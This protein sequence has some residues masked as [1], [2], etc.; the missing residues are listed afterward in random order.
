MHKKKSSSTASAVKA[1]LS[2]FATLAAAVPVHAVSLPGNVADHTL[3]G[4]PSMVV[5][6]GSWRETTDVLVR[7]TADGLV[8][9]GLAAKGWNI[10]A[11]DDDWMVRTDC[12]DWDAARTPV[13]NCSG[14]RDANGH[15]IA[16]PSKYPQGIQSTINY[17]H[18]KGLKF[19][20]YTDGGS[21]TCDGGAAMNA[22]SGPTYF[23]SD[24]NYFASMGVD[25]IKSDYCYNINNTSN[26]WPLTTDSDATVAVDAYRQ[27][28]LA[29]DAANA[30]YGTH[31]VL[32]PSPAAYFNWHNDATGTA[33]FQKVVGGLALYAQQWRI[34]G[35]NGGSTWSSML[36]TLDQ[37]VGTA[38]FAR[39]GHFN[40]LDQLA[41]GKG[42]MTTA[43]GQSEFSLWAI[44]AAPLNIKVGVTTGLTAQLVSDAG[45]TDVIAISQ[46]Q[47]GAQGKRIYNDAN[48]SVFTKPLANGD[49]AVLLLNKSTTAQTISTSG[50]AVGTSATQFS[51]TDV[52]SKAV[53][54]STGSISASVPATS[55]ILYRLHPTSNAFSAW[56]QARNASSISDDDASTAGCFDSACRSFSSDALAS[57]GV[58]AGGSITVGGQTF[59]NWVGGGAG[60]L[61]SI[62]AQGQTI[63][64]SAVSRSYIGFLGASNGGDVSGTL[65]LNY[66]DGTSSTVTLGFPD[67]QSVNPS[68]FG[69][70]TAVVTTHANTQT[71]AQVSGN[72]LISQA[73]FALPAGKSVISITLPNQPALRIFS[74]TT[75]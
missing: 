6:P 74:I 16:S 4:V 59:T 19:G 45:N 28:A 37:G 50:T 18:S 46:D 14:G 72:H 43:Q 71:K 32:T 49:Y 35:D 29:V 27:T 51:L 68:A 1:A 61:D 31:M 53:S 58:A 44:M 34:G 17:V 25:Y 54:T 5:R 10:V 12:T 23:I 20:I 7:S 30:A 33:A 55:A 40:D 24:S 9:T 52:W 47:I 13:P 73:K 22:A 70:T 36:T 63:S 26:G 38:A 41:M 66:S 64:Y 56:R 62:I 21:K 65:T 15:P 75:S 60:Q 3:Q 2:T 69:D 39:A 8:S 57:A 67:W 11:V 48:T 42:S